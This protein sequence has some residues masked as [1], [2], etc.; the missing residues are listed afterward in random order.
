MEVWDGIRWERF[1]SNNFYEDEARTVCQQLG[2]LDY[3]TILPGDQFG[4]GYAPPSDV[5]FHC[6]SNDN[7]LAYCYIVA[8]KGTSYCGSVAVRCKQPEDDSE[9]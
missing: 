3:E 9:Y 4:V 5:G 7:E 8:I 6:G 1:C 2:Y